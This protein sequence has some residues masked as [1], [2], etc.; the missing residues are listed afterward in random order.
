MVEVKS[1]APANPGAK[2]A[3]AS[4]EANLPWL[5]CVGPK[6]SR[7]AW[8]VEELRNERVDVVQWDEDPRNVARALSPR[9]DP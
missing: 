7:V 4:P 2:V 5:A 6:G 9:K 3:V 1:I 8:F